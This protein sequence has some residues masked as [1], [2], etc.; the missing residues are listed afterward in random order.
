MSQ[1]TLFARIQDE[2][3][4]RTREKKR[5]GEGDECDEV[6]NSLEAIANSTQP[7]ETSAASKIL[8]RAE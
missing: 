4:E 8:K 7:D 1:T 5:R 2:A 6:E 3:R